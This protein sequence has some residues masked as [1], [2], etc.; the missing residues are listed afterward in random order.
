[1][2][3]RDDINLARESILTGLANLDVD[4]PDVPVPPGLTGVE[5]EAHAVVVAFILTLRLWREELEKIL[6][7]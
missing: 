3:T 2:S 1:M 5:T 7:G 6:E 4:N